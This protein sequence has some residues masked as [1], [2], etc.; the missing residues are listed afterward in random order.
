MNHKFLWIIFLVGGLGSLLFILSG[1]EVEQVDEG[2]SASVQV[3]HDEDLR[4]WS[5]AQWREKLTEGQYQVLRR[6]R[7]ERAHTSPL[8]NEDRAGV[9]ACAGC[10]TPLFSSETKYDSRTG[11]PSFWQVIKEGVIEYKADR[12]WGMRLTEVVCARCGGH[13]GHVFNDGPP[14]TGQRYCING[15]ALIFI[16][17]E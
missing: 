14:P 15:L 7:T 6:K 2:I 11:W 10:G 5:D 9:F 8:L 12:S 4:A 3:G 1:S 17:V 13:L 16:P